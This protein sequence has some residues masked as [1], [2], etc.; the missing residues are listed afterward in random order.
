MCDCCGG[1]RY[2]DGLRT[3][4]PVSKMFGVRNLPFMFS[5]CS[6]YCFEHFK[7]ADNL[8]EMLYGTT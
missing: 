5:L 3:I 8:M 1:T 4:R 6:P 2:G 7:T